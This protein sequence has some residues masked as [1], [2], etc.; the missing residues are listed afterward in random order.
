MD[1]KKVGIFLKQLRK[2]N[3]MTQEQ[4]G[5]RIGVTNKTVSRWETGNYMPPVECLELLS[6]IYQIS[7]NEILAGERVADENLK[8]V[9]DENL[10]IVLGELQQECQKFE[11][12]MFFIFAVTTILTIAII[13]LL[14][15]KSVKDIVIFIMVIVMGFISNTLNLV[16]LVLNKERY[17][18]DTFCSHLK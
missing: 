9:A 7:I 1:T 6:D 14:P 2:E 16:A 4:L 10:S 3:D 12:R 13:F 8:G 17:K 18:T 5:E 11:K 15:L